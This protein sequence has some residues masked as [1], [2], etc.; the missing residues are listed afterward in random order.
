M[1]E[2][3]I[4]ESFAAAHLIR[5]YPGDCARLHGHTWFVEVGI[6]GEELDDL[7]ML[8]D[9]SKLKQI[10]RSY[11]KKLDHQLINDLPEFREGE[12][13]PTAE[14]LA[15]YLYHQISQVIKKEWPDKKIALGWVKVWESPTAWAIYRRG[16]NENISG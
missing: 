15:F 13:N 11:L 2:V 9:F 12:L 1:F 7:G 5:N 10:V 14:N 6:Y 8:I 16:K 3:A 4:K